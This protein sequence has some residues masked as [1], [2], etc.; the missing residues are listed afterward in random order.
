MS[1]IQ[2]ET[3]KVYFKNEAKCGEAGGFGGGC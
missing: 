1:C 3:R 2:L